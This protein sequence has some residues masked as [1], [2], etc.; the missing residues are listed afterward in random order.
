MH[1]N[2]LVNGTGGLAK[3]PQT[4]QIMIISSHT[5]VVDEMQFFIKS[6]AYKSICLKY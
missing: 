2:C 3:G 6:P 5:V 4:A 1:T